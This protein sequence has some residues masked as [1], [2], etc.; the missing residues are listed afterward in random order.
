MASHIGRVHLRVGCVGVLCLLA[1]LG[2]GPTTADSS[3]PVF[4]GQAT[5]VQANVLNL[6]PITLADT[7]YFEAPEFLP[8]APCTEEGISIPNVSVG[9]EILC[10]STRGKGDHSMSNAHVAAL[11]ASVAGIPVT[12]ALVITR[13]RKSDGGPTIADRDQAGLRPGEPRLDEERAVEAGDRRSCLSGCIAHR[14][15]LAGCEAVGLDDDASVSKLRHERDR[16]GLLVG[17]K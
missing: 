11:D 9:A 14:D 3:R 16:R 2:G 7:G 12:E 17:S 5:A 10:A 6:Q 4:S 13:Q 8:P 15:A 1:S